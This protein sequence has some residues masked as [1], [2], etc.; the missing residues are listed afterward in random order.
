MTPIGPV[1]SDAKV[2]A[3]VVVGQAYKQ[4]GFVEPV[5]YVLQ[6]CEADEFQVAVV[7]STPQ[8]CT[9]NHGSSFGK[10]V[11]VVLDAIAYPLDVSMNWPDDVAVSAY[12]P[13]ALVVIFTLCP[14]ILL[15]VVFVEFGV[16]F[17][18]PKF[19]T[20]DVADIPEFVTSVAEQPAFPVLQATPFARPVIVK[21]REGSTVPKTCTESIVPI[22]ALPESRR[23]LDA[24]YV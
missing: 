16:L 7:T 8:G 13:A 1:E 15:T 11:G 24:L 4:T 2:S 5:I 12:P 6:V 23:V 19:T 18:S 21:V 3:V 20:V 22:V 10:A 14:E 9:P 17:K